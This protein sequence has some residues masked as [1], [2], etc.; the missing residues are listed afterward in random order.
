MGKQRLHGGE[1]RAVEFFEGMDQRTKILYA[2]VAVAILLAGY[3][4]FLQLDDSPP[5]DPNQPSNPIGQPRFN[6]D[7]N[8][9]PFGEG[10]NATLRE[11]IRQGA[12]QIQRDQDE[13]NE[14]VKTQNSQFVEGME[15]QFRDM[16]D[17]QFKPYGQH[18]VCRDYLGNLVVCD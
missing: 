10:P 17:N 13:F 15:Q 11:S 1:E 9:Q 12:E 3:S 5:I 2:G 8:V 6:P 7:S 16:R 4:I 18:P 14:R